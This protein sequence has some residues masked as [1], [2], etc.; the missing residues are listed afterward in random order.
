MFDFSSLP[1]TP[2]DCRAGRNYFGF[3]QAKFARESGLPDHKIKRFEAGN[4]IPDE[5]FLTAMRDFFVGRGYQFQ[6]TPKPGDRAVKSGQVFPA[7]VVAGAVDAEFPQAAGR[8][9]RTSFHHM[10][11]AITD[12]REMGEM[13][14]IIEANE[15]KVGDVLNKPV[16]AG[17][18]GG[19]INEATERRHAQVISFLAENATL[20]AKLFGRDIGGKPAADILK[21]SKKPATNAD[22]LHQVQADIHL[23]S[24]GDAAAKARQKAKKETAPAS[25]ILQAIGLS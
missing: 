25:S 21:G 15:E 12:E 20:F 4:Y 24:S 14:D 6:N 10:R 16:E 23:A 17:F 13:M 9:T 18:F 3:S 19:G 22:L 1:L 7:G 11:I 2:D 5:A 8:P